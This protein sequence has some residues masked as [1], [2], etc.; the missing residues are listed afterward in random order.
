MS[1]NY[2]KYSLERLDEWFH[3]LIHNEDVT[4]TEIVNQLMKTLTENYEYHSKYSK[5]CEY[6]MKLLQSNMQTE[7]KVTKWILPVEQIIEEGIDNYFI[8]LPDDLLE[9]VNWKENDTLEWVDN[10]NGSYTLQKV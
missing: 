10:G 6:L 4:P 2:T 5:R 8:T 3:D 9:T 7:D 1:E